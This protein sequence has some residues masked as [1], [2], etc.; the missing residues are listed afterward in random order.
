[1]PPKSRKR[2]PPAVGD[3]RKMVAVIAAE[4]K[5]GDATD[6]FHAVRRRC[7]EWAVT[8][9]RVRK[10]L[11][12]LQRSRKK[13]SKKR[14]SGGQS[15]HDTVARAFPHDIVELKA[16]TSKARHTQWQ[17]RG[18]VLRVAGYD[19]GEGPDEEDQELPN[20]HCSVFW[21]G[22]GLE[23]WPNAL[24][25]E[26]SLRVLDRPW[27]LGDRVARADDPRSLG[28]IVGVDCRLK[29]APT[30]DP[31]G[32]PVR[33]PVQQ[34]RPVG[35]FRAD[36]W[37][38]H[39]SSQWV[40]RVVEAV[41]RVEVQLCSRGEPRPA[42][43]KSRQRAATCA[44][45]VSSEGL[46][47]LE[48]AGREDVTPQELSPH[49]PGQRIRAPARL[50]RQ[51]EWVRGS[52]GR[53]APR[54]GAV[55]CGVVISVECNL[56]AVRWL[57][58]L[59]KE[60]PPPDEW[61]NPELVRVLAMPNSSEGWAIGDHVSLDPS[62]TTRT[63]EQHAPIHVIVESAT[64]VDVRWADGTV[65]CGMSS[66]ELCPRPHISAHDFLPHN[67]VARSPAGFDTA[68]LLANTPGVQPVQPVEPSDVPADSDVNMDTLNNIEAEYASH[69]QD[70]ASAGV[71]SQFGIHGGGVAEGIGEEIVAT[72]EI[73]A[74]GNLGLPNASMML[75]ETPVGVVKTVN[76][77]ARTAVVQWLSQGT[78]ADPE[79]VSVFELTE[80]PFIDV[81]L[82][83][84]VLIPD[85]LPE[86]WAGR[87][88]ALRWDGHALVERTD[89]SSWWYDVR[90]LVVVDEEQGGSDPGAPSGSEDGST[91]SEC[92]G[93]D[94][95]ATELDEADSG[96]ETAADADA[97][98]VC[99]TA[100]KGQQ[101][102][103]PELAN[104]ASAV[105]TSAQQDIGAPMEVSPTS[106]QPL[107]KDVD[108]KAAAA[109]EDASCMEITSDILPFDVCEDDVEPTDHRFFNQ[110]T[111]GTKALMMAVRRE[112]VVLR[113]GLLEGSEGCAASIVVRT[114]SSRSDL[115]RA[116][117]AGPPDTPYAHVPFFFDLA[118]P[119]GYP[120]EP[121]LAHFH[122]HYAGAER[123]NPNLYADGKVCLSLLGTWSGPSW[124]PQIS[125][126]LQVLVS[127]QGLVL[128][129]EPYFNEPGHECDVGTEQGRQN[130]ALYNEHARLLALRA[131]LNVASHPPRGFQQIVENHFARF[132][133]KLVQECEEALQEDKAQTHSEGFRKVLGKSLLPRLRE[134]WGQG[135]QAPSAF[136]E[137]DSVAN[138]NAPSNPDLECLPAASSEA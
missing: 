9:H 135:G 82:S 93:S 8:P 85:A 68:D 47:G 79:E 49:F 87:V 1:M 43:G 38:A 132:G 113:K 117:V 16:S 131:A 134:R 77:Q 27:V 62:C 14:Q 11:A 120:R 92:V 56:L 31:D 65:E 26:S 60:S 86:Q 81:R 32:A 109:D 104:S 21:L 125:T 137:P 102:D 24:T 3:F 83:D 22:Q 128:V 51:G 4:L 119:A 138:S 103:E 95:D 64:N 34:A 45:Q 46:Q 20:G 94:L 55:I 107:L 101:D 67:F 15:S 74:H 108:D 23:Q 57:A 130:S 53:N 91:A 25:K 44:F 100:V 80:H 28:T 75:T 127:L 123:L 129:E 48:P 37:V 66:L 121:P 110:T 89:G 115:F 96:G 98:E 71:L 18:Q 17:W 72:S 33:V 111:L 30:G 19:D 42:R 105:E 76:M 36:D 61:V 122:A 6:V 58:G 136:Q 10:A 84:I 106:K 39:T 13:A 116:M 70:E 69:V 7:P 118:L 88:S 50:W 78:D 59:A 40:G 5:S 99:D 126:L 2:W 12:A 112:M 54:R 73:V 97:M 52:V 124:E 63:S 90:Q 35:G 114:Y 29:F 41:F 133:P